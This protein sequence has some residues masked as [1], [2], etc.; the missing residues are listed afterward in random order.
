[1]CIT[2]YKNIWIPK[3]GEVLIMKNKGGNIYDRLACH[4]YLRVASI[5][6]RVDIQRGVYSRAVFFQG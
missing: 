5:S 3:L 1:M 2:Y 4:M 6:F